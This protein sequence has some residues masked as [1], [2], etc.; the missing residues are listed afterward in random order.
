LNSQGACAFRGIICTIGETPRMRATKRKNGDHHSCAAFWVKGIVETLKGEG[1]DVAALLDEAGLDM[2]ALSD[3]DSRLPTERVSL[4]WQLAVARSGNPAIGLL[5][6]NVAKPASFDVVGYTMMSSPNLRSVLQGVVRYVGILSDAASLTVTE[7]HEGYRM[8]LEL[9]GG[10]P[11]VPR[12]RVEFDLMTFL[13]F[14]RWITNRDLRPLALELRF[15]PPADLQPYQEAFKCPLRF[16][17]PT[18]AL[19]FAR[20]DVI[21][22]LP[23]AHPLLAEVHERLASE[24]LQRLDHAQTSSRAR[25]AIIRRLPDGEPRR[26]GIAGALGISERTLQR[27]LEAEGTF[28]QRLLDDTRRELAQQYLG[29]TDLSLADAAYL[30]GFGDQSSFF[31]AVKRWF[32]TSPRQYRIH[33]I[34]AR[35]IGS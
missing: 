24:H 8:S 11:P 21:S 1:L 35:R 16:N 20:A 14:C 23:T 27:R 29:Q 2:A 12:Q 6:P 28:F 19:L 3:P 18:N 4:L 33:L 13:S 34:G 15:P 32:G 7:D 17:A 10:G 31:R 22:P 25:A 30:L 5:N 26:P 9:F